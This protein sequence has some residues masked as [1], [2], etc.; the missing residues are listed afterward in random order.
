MMVRLDNLNNISIQ[1]CF[2]AIVWTSL[3]TGCWSTG[4]RTARS[5][6]V[7]I[8]H[9]V[10]SN[11]LGDRNYPPNPASSP[12]YDYL[13]ENVN[14][15]FGFKS[16][17]LKAATEDPVYTGTETKLLPLYIPKGAIP[18]KLAR[19]TRSGSDSS[20]SSLRINLRRSRLPSSITSRRQGGPRRPNPPP[21][22]P[23]STPSFLRGWGR[24]IAPRAE[25][26]LGLEVEDS[27]TSASTQ[28]HTLKRPG[29]QRTSSGDLS[30]RSIQSSR[31][32]TSTTETPTTITTTLKTTSP[33]P[34]PS[35]VVSTTQL[36]NNFSLNSTVTSTTENSLDEK[37]NKESVSSFEQADKP[38]GRQRKQDF[39]EIKPDAL[40]LDFKSNRTNSRVS[41]A[42][43]RQVSA[44]ESSQLRQSR[45]STTESTVE[46]DAIQTLEVDNKKIEVPRITTFQ[47]IR[48]TIQSRVTSDDGKV[49][50]VEEGETENDPASVRTNINN[51]RFLFPTR[52]T[53]PKS[54]TEESVGS[55]DSNNERKSGKFR[56]PLLSLKSSNVEDNK[57]S[58]AEASALRETSSETGTQNA[59]SADS[60]SPTP[61]PLPVRRRRPLRTRL[62]LVEANSN[63]PNFASFRHDILTSRSRSTT[64]TTTDAPEITTS[65]TPR[66]TASTTTELT[67]SHRP[68]LFRSTPSTTTANVR[69]IHDFFKISAD[70]DK[71]SRK[72]TTTTTT[73][74]IPPRLTTTTEFSVIL[75]S[76]TQRS[77]IYPTTNFW[78][79]SA[80]RKGSHSAR[81]PKRVQ[82]NP[83][84]PSDRKSVV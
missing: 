49:K 52:P 80:N 14:G 83:Q 5:P 36:K 18:I 64:T 13:L 72:T 23:A 34:Q 17:F 75:N 24:R 55:N 28:S 76:T 48:E 56:M 7:T 62:P 27:K 57:E 51:K 60:K 10:T 53:T 66:I 22:I 20:G 2:I 59:S 77:T 47:R 45:T 65:T 37:T 78:H 15:D 54:D 67:T 8:P 31:R 74:T 16:S 38:F 42:F 12:D 9:F 32:T 43:I 69:R 29:F 25:S 1:S 82:G 70:N 68:L 19:I 41:S 33:V 46:N 44:G 11:G 40:R 6:G 30:N 61:S 4:L 84:N 73:T 79:K 63:N 39:V 71:F 3:I 26:R 35:I 58:A 50:N 81:P 21:A